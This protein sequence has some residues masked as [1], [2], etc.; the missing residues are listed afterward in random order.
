MFV[1]SRSIHANIFYVA[2]LFSFLRFLFLRFSSGERGSS[3]D[4]RASVLLRTLCGG[5]PCEARAHICVFLLGGDKA[6]IARLQSGLL[7][8]LSHPN[9][10]ALV[11]FSRSS[12][13]EKSN[14]PSKHHQKHHPLQG[15]LAG[16]HQGSWLRAGRTDSKESTRLWRA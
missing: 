7:P 5:R 15:K 1:F 6:S 16:C 2:N 14:R 3:A 9:N 12:S 8:A 13:Y 4:I 11:C 10:R